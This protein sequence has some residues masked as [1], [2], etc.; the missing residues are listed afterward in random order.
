MQ[1]LLVA[2]RGEI[3]VRILR[4][5]RAAGLSSVAVYSEADRDA[6][7]VALADQAC[8]IGPAS[9]TESYLRAANILEA[10]HKTGADAIHPGYGFLS[11]N[12]DFAQQCAEAGLIFVGPPADVMRKVGDKIAAKRIMEAAGVPVVPGYN[13]DEQSEPQLQAEATRIGAPL[14]IK[15]AAGGGGRGMRVVRDLDSFA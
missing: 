5:C 9:A 13:G 14:L 2:N 11:E 6:P 12:A 10:A 3:A 7:H 8:C 15:A 1:R 4:A